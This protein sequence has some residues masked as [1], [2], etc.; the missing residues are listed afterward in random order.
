MLR[1]LVLVLIILVISFVLFRP[2]GTE[3]EPPQ[4]L[5]IAFKP[6]ISPHGVA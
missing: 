2:M 4:H 5:V 1:K 6:M 3:P